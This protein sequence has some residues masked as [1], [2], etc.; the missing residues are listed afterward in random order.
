MAFKSIYDA[1]DASVAAHSLP[2]GGPPIATAARVLLDVNGVEKFSADDLA[3]ALANLLASS[4][5]FN[6]LGAAV[7]VVSPYTPVTTDT[8]TALATKRDETASL[9][10]AGTIAAATFVFPTNAN[11]RIGQNLTLTSTQIVTALTVSSSGLTLLGTAVT[12][13][14]VNTPVSWRKVA[15]STWLRTL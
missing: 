3:T 2:V 8:I 11:S 7:S 4:G 13:L 15:A 1:V 5:A 12:A 9:V 6:A 10:P 14:A